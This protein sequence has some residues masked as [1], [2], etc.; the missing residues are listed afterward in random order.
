MLAVLKRWLGF[1]AATATVQATEVS[2]HA[3]D[4][5]EILVAIGDDVVLFSDTATARQHARDVLELCDETD[6]VGRDPEA[7]I[8]QEYRDTKE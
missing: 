6:G 2:Y 1:E 5:G 8:W 3:T 7:D 4:A